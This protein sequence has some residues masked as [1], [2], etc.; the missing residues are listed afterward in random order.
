MFSFHNQPDFHTD[1]P[2][3]LG[4]DYSAQDCDL[5]L[6]IGEQLRQLPVPEGLAERVAEASLA[7]W[8][9]QSR[10]RLGSPRVAVV[11]KRLALAACVAV[12]VVAAFWVTSPGLEPNNSGSV[13][14]DTPS[15]ETWVS[16][17]YEPASPLLGILSAMDSSGLVASHDLTWEE[18]HDELLNILE[19]EQTSDVWGY[20]A[21][22]IR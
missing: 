22:E 11:I 9:S 3:P 16:D 2:D 20:L 14:L 13:V 1:G 19:A 15:L 8:R 18:T 21:V 7:E 5:D 6:K 4:P 12:A 10:M 17:E